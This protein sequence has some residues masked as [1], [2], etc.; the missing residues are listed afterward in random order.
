M[1]NHCLYDKN[2]ILLRERLRGSRA[3]HLRSPLI[4]HNSKIL[5]PTLSQI[6]LSNMFWS[7]SLTMGFNRYQR[8]KMI[9]VKDPSLDVRQRPAVPRGGRPHEAGTLENH[10]NVISPQPN[11]LD[12]FSHVCQ[13]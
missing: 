3:G 11:L 12:Y 9:K 7:P 1:A 8:L 5:R 2:C 6:S 13:A 4:N 10:R